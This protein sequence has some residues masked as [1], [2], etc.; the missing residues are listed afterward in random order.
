MQT[1]YAGAPSGKNFRKNRFFETLR[2][3]LLVKVPRDLSCD[4]LNVV[5]GLGSAAVAASA[6]GTATVTAPRDL[7]IRDLVI[8]AP[9][10]CVVTSITVSGDAVLLGSPVPIETF[11]QG[12]QARPEFDLPV[13]GGTT[14]QVNYTNGATAGQFGAAF[15]ID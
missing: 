12:N 2:S 3:T 8:A 4:E 1:S 7:I 13:Q 14:I 9:A 6:S 5:L 15:N 10:G 11:S